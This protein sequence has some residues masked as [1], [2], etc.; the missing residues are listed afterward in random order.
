MVD[1]LD[2]YTLTYR[3]AEARQVMGW[4]KAGQSGCLIGLRGAGKSNFL[5]FLLRQD[6]RRHYL[7]QDW[8]DFAFVLIDLLALTERT[9]WAVYELMLDRLLGVEEE[10][11]EEMASLHREVAHSRDS[12][13]AQRAIERCVDVLCQ[14]PGQRIILLFD[15]FIQVSGLDLIFST[16]GK[17]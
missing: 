8:A 9:E 11:V 5:R 3:V 15:E 10:I 14:R 12:L 2:R 7:G 4:I 6:V 17:A 1:G 16:S 13:M